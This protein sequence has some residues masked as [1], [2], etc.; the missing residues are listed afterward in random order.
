MIL[1]KALMALY[2]IVQQLST[3]YYSL[4]DKVNSW[5]SDY[6]AAP[7]HALD[8][9]PKRSGIF[10]DTH[11]QRVYLFGNARNHEGWYRQQLTDFV[12]E[13]TEHCTSKAKPFLEKLSE[14][15]LS[16]TDKIRGYAVLDNLA[17]PGAMAA[18]A[19]NGWGRIRAL[20]V[21]TAFK[22]LAERYARA[23][24]R[25]YEEMKEYLLNHEIVHMFGI[26]KERILE[27][28]SAKVYRELAE[29]AQKKGDMKAAQKYEAFASICDQRYR[30]VKKNYRH[31]RH[32]SAHQQETDQEATAGNLE[33]LLTEEGK[34][35]KGDG[36]A[37]GEEAGEEGSEAEG[38][39][40]EAGGEGGE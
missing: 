17:A 10:Y 37:N 7:A 9:V 38:G 30:D 32:A 6:M 13:F 27:Y 26:Y 40:G 5:Y 31:L 23:V 34:K 24:G 22:P 4:S 28:V 36:K 39:E 18:V 8:P 20:I 15:G 21:P 11:S 14:Y 19:H 3:K 33:S 12:Q 25:S 16:M 1:L 35:S 2:D 29:K